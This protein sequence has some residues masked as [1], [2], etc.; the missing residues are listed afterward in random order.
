M[1]HTEGHAAHQLHQLF[2]LSNL[3]GNGGELV[4][5]HKQDFEGEAE[6]V[7]WQ[8]RQKI[9]AVG[10][11]ENSGLHFKTAHRSHWELSFSKRGNV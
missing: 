5:A 8:N 3:I 6:Q 1:Q 2:G 4:V 11:R 9:S 7:F 10:G